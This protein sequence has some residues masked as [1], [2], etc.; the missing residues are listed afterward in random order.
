MF[1]SLFHLMKTLFPDIDR[2]M[3]VNINISNEFGSVFVC[4]YSSHFLVL[5]CVCMLHPACVLVEIL[6]SSSL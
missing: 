3:C 4:F 6:D 5:T 1:V 2:D